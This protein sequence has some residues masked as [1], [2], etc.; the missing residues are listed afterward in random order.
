ML[1]PRR[2]G[3]RTRLDS[4]FELSC[5]R[6]RV[7]R[8]ESSELLETTRNRSMSQVRIA[9]Y[10]SWTRGRPSSA[11]LTSP[12]TSADGLLACLGESRCER[13]STLTGPNDNRIKP[14]HT[15]GS[16]HCS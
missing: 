11:D 15:R 10:L 13:R 9:S 3:T 12:L 1:R 5:S 8:V 4:A 16:R 14:F 2:V 7:G 6:G